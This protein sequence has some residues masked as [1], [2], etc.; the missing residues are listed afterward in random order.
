MKAQRSAKLPSLFH[1]ACS[2][3]LAGTHVITCKPVDSE[4]QVAIVN[5]VGTN[6]LG[7]VAAVVMFAAAIGM[8][9]T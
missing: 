6:I 3:Q 5:G 7:W 4:F 8:L 9:M 2:P 1:F